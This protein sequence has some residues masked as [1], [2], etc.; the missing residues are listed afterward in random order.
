MGWKLPKEHGAWAMLY[1]PLVLGVAAARQVPG[2]LLWLVAAVTLL[3]MARESLALWLRAARQH[4]SSGRLPAQMALQIS[5]AA[6]CGGWLIGREQRFELLPLAAVAALLFAA[7]A[8]QLRRREQRSIAAEIFAIVG[9]TSSAPAA[10]CV[11][12]GG[13]AAI[14]AW[15]WV[16]SALYF[17][18]SVFY[19]KLRV[20]DLQVR[21]AGGQRRLR[22]ATAVYHLALA[23]VVLAL[24]LRHVFGSGLALAFAPILARTAW[25]LWRPARTLSLRR[26]GVFEI[27]YS[28]GFLACAAAAVPPPHR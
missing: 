4:R 7:Q 8:V 18:S 6:A 3:F 10:Y 28:L 12:R 21:R 15:L 16:V 22:V 9:L 5:L 24:V 19:V 20:A 25:A 14:A 23:G 2:R 1:A 13:F 11:A 27:L 17:A 26:I